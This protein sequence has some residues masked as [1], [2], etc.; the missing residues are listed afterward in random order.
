MASFDEPQKI[1]TGLQLLQAGIIDRQTLQEEMDG[2]ENI[3]AIN[4]RITKEKAERVLFESLLQRSQQGDQ[5]AL[6]AI[7]DIFNKPAQM[8]DVLKLYFTP[9]E[10]QMSPEEEAFVQTQAGQGQGPALPQQP[11]SLQQALGMIGG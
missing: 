11:P 1:V 8:G 3:T 6:L 5:G 10:P 7:V 2:L 4:D 9:Q